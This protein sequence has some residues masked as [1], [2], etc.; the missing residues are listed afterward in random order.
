MT[1]NHRLDS[2]YENHLVMKLI[3]VSGML[4]LYF[5]CFV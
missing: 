4:G 3:L 5:F 2:S 1:E